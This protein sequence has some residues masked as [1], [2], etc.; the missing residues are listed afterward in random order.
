MRQEL[1]EKTK[2]KKYTVG[3]TWCSVCE[4]YVYPLIAA[5]WKDGKVRRHC[6]ECHNRVRI[7]PPGYAA[8]YDV[9]RH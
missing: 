4:I 5:L 7:R 1:A 6:P 8:K 3:E 2:F 9:F